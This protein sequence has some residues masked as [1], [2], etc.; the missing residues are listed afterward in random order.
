MPEA[1]K[2]LCFP[3]FRYAKEEVRPVY[4]LEKNHNG[5]SLN[6]ATKRL[7]KSIKK[8]P[9]RSQ[10]TTDQIANEEFAQDRYVPRSYEIR[11]DDV[12]LKKR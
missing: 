12:T 4:N 9:L 1:Q 11:Y 8:I 2:E 6:K 3:Q 5:V 10:S 7:D